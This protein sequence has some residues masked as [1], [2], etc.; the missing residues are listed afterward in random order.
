MVDLIG[1]EVVEFSKEAVASI[2]TMG[3]SPAQIN[4]KV[5][6]LFSG[7]SKQETYVLTDA[8]QGVKE[9]SSGEEDTNE[10]K[11]KRTKNFIKSILNKVTS[12]DVEYDPKGG[13]LVVSKEL[14]AFPAEIEQYVEKTVRIYGEGS[15]INTESIEYEET[16]Y[17]P[18]E[19]NE[20]VAF[21]FFQVDYTFTQKAT[22]V[23]VDPPLNGKSVY[24]IGD[25]V[26][27]KETAFIFSSIGVTRVPDYLVVHIPT[28]FD[29][30]GGTKVL[31]ISEDVLSDTAFYNFRHQ[32][33]AGSVSTGNVSA[34]LLSENLP[35]NFQTSEYLLEHGM[36]DIVADRKQHRKI[37][38]NILNITLSNKN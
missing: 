22:T 35:E 24:N 18:L 11:S 3:V 12:V 25:S 32:F 27:I 2:E 6:N 29:I 26:L 5:S 16:I 23:Q 30:S 14:L 1:N 21:R 28:L 7:V 31:K 20:Q 4:S 17:V 33:S 8:T 38:S 36:I 10:K 15:D 19:L 9:P 13:K 37:L 34:K